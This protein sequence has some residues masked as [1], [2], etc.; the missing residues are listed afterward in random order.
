MRDVATLLS[1]L[2]CCSSWDLASRMAELTA[3]PA[4]KRQL[5]VRN[6]RRYSEPQLARSCGMRAQRLWGESWRAALEWA[7]LA[8]LI[9][10]QR[11]APSVAVQEDLLAETKGCLGN[12]LRLAGRHSAELT[13]EEAREHA[14]AGTGDPLLEAELACFLGALR[15]RQRS[16]LSASSLFLSAE[17]LARSVGQSVTVARASIGHA[18]A[19]LWQGKTESAVAVMRATLEEHV[20]PS[21]DPELGLLALH[22]LALAIEAR[23]NLELALLIMKKAFLLNWPDGRIRRLALAR[24][25]QYAAGLLLTLGRGE[26]AAVYLEQVATTLLEAELADDAAWCMVEV[27]LARASDSHKLM[28]ALE[29]AAEIFSSI[30]RQG[31]VA[32]IREALSN[33]HAAGIIPKIVLLQRSRVRQT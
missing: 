1:S 8:V 26:E 25:K 33:S 23:G 17:S 21:E 32:L 2:S 30:G 15:L 20:D 16:F 24:A 18:R 3:L 4:E 29:G 19:L 28:K 31:E 12:V 27:A 14:R 5:R 6:Q 7:E 13:L 9:A 10:E 11:H 22:A